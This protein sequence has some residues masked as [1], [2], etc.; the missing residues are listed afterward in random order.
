MASDAEQGPDG[1]HA[2]RDALED[3]A[4][5][6]RRARLDLQ[7]MHEQ[8]SAASRALS[9]VERQVRSGEREDASEDMNRVARRSQEAADLG[10]TVATRLRNADQHIAE[11]Q[12]HVG[13]IDTSGLSAQES[14]DVASLRARV[15]SYGKAVQLAGPMATAASEHLYGAS[16]LAARA[17]QYDFSEVAPSEALDAGSVAPVAHDL[18]RAQEAER[19]LG[20]TVE[21]A[22]DVG[23]KS[24]D[25][26]QMAQAD[27]RALF[28][29][30]RL[31]RGASDGQAPLRRRA[32]APLTRLA[33]G[34]QSS[35]G[36][37]PPLLVILRCPGASKARGGDSRERPSELDN[38]RRH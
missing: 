1:I 10:I 21:L 15:D 31:S 11:A 4:L 16:H 30:D 34:W 17:A 6:I 23:Q 27:T 3:A 7:D 20:R 36:G 19:H 12:D 14:A 24:L 5:S 28:E 35:L 25:S 8:V 29:A 37:N 13:R 22:D 33:P 26:A 38:G 2:A 32:S 18:G 9:D